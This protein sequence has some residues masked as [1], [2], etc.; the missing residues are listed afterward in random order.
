MDKQRLFV[1]MDGTLA[2]FKPV[3]TL[4]TLYEKG[5]FLNLEPHENVVSAIKEI[6]KNNPEI[7]V[8]ILSAYLTDSKYALDEK[9]A[10]VEKY[11]PEIP[12][13]NRVFVPCGAN[14]R[15][16]IEGGVRPNDFL[17]DDY[18]KNLNDWQPPARGIKLL[19]AINHTRGSWS[20]DRIRFD[21]NPKDLALGIV[22]IMQ[23]KERV[24]DEKFPR[25]DPNNLSGTE[26]IVQL[27]E[28]M[29]K[30]LAVA[31]AKVEG[32]DLDIAMAGRLTDL[33]D[34]IDWRKVLKGDAPKEKINIKQMISLNK[35]ESAKKPD[36]PSKVKSNDHEL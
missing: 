19:N 25:I 33:E 15:E 28:D 9:N 29:Q 23:G 8:N 4:E 14:K 1:D 7:E 12:K 30:K 32:S 34:C 35:D 20:F 10:W 16:C 13:E 18:T 2:V 22:G 11:L 21:R 3:D 24:I 27:P 31:L 26:F 5:Y 17:L 6:I 36:S